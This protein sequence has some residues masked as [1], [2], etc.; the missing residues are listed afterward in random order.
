MPRPRFDSTIN[1]P[2]VI[3]ALAILGGMFAFE[4]NQSKD[5]ST[6]QADIRQLQRISAQVAQDN[7]DAASDRR[8]MA[9][10]L[11]RITAILDGHIANTRIHSP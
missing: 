3:S 7:A 4:N 1:I 9:E 2:T 5:L 8:R 6:T 10:T 11:S